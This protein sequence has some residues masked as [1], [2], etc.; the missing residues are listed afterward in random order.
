[1]TPIDTFFKAVSYTLITSGFATLA[2]TGKVDGFSIVV[3][4]VAIILSWRAD[5]PDS[6]LQ[7][8]ATTANRFVLGF[9]PFLWVDYRYVSNSW[10]LVLI[11]F[12]LF[13]SIFKLFQVKED[14]DWVFLYLLAVFEVLLAAG[15]TIDAVFIVCLVVFVMSGLAALEAFEIKRAQ[16]GIRPTKTE[17]A[18]SHD[19]LHL[20]K[21]ARP[22][23]LLIVATGVMGVLI[24]CLSV[25]VFFLIPRVNTGLLAYNAPESSITMSGFSDSVELGSVG[26]IQM[27]RKVVMYVRVQGSADATRKLR[28]RGLALS[29]FTGHSW[30]KNAF[31]HKKQHLLPDSRGVFLLDNRPVPVER[32]STQTF[33]LEPMGTDVLFAAGKP[34]LLNSQFDHLAV[35][36]TNSLYTGFHSTQRLSYTVVA[37]SVALTEEAMRSDPG[38]Y[39]S[40][41]RAFYLQLPD[42]FDPRIRQ[43]AQ[44][45]V[46]S[47]QTPYAKA[48]AIEKYLKSKLTYTL[49]QTPTP[50]ETDPLIDFLFLRQK[51][52]CEYFASAMT[53]ML[54]SVG[55]AARVANGFQTGE[56]NSINNSYTVRQSDAHSWVEVYFP[57]AQTWS[58]FDPTPPAGPEATDISF[59]GYFNRYLD[60]LR[61]FWI[62]WV[63]TYDTDRQKSLAQTAQETVIGYQSKYQLWMKSYRERVSAFLRQFDQVA[64]GTLHH[65]M[66]PAALWSIAF[67][68]GALILVMQVVLLIRR[69][70]TSPE[71]F[72]ASWW[73]RWFLV[74]WIRLTAPKNP[75]GAAVLFY[76]EMLSIMARFGWKKPKYLTP[77]EFAAQT[78]MPEVLAVTEYYNRVRYGRDEQAALDVKRMQEMLKRVKEAVRQRRKRG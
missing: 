1:M 4:L 71:T 78:H 75:Q 67:L 70:R 40:D 45:V 74:P 59:S 48:V 11:H 30:I 34:L 14:R 29:T 61:L 7:I 41:I 77:L 35:D 53:I 21:S 16:Q 39:T 32:R 57:N 23:R 66:F 62:D 50:G 20:K 13:V 76:N 6:G 25:P 68:T 8:Q 65:P 33:Y 54:R 46:G 72:F 5:K 49:D 73:S 44:Q 2:L 63:V 19:G 55:V 58:E 26:K 51:G 9:L 60:A 22:T 56:Y 64:A 47:A 52:H 31:T 17:R 10:I 3:Y 36:R 42:T 43:L 12:F 15:L 27:S 37:E 24:V 28:W 38:N 69:L 18:F